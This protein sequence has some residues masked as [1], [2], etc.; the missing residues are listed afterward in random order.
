[1]RTLRAF[2]ALMV[3]A[4][5]LTGCMKL[6]MDLSIDP[7]N[8][9]LNGAFIVAVHKNV[10]TMEGK[11]AE[12]GFAATEKG[13]KEIPPGTRSEVYDDGMFYGRRIIFEQ[14]PLAEFNRQNPSASITH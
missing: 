1:M 13:L 6:D 14:Y 11:T 10:L 4:L 9:T 8:D 2:T 5:T 7:R 12:Q 3:A